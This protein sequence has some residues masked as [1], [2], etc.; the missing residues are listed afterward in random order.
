MIRIKKAGRGVALPV[1]LF[2]FDQLF[3]AFGDLLALIM[4]LLP[5]RSVRIWRNKYEPGIALDKSNITAFLKLFKEFW[6]ELRSNGRWQ[7]IEIE[8]AGL[9][10]DIRFY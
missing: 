4:D 3:E 6:D 9:R 10:I 2:V 7:L 1:P 5:S 8:A